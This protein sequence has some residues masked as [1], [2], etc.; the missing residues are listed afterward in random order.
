MLLRIK[1][2][3]L[4]EREVWRKGEDGVGTLL[5]FDDSGFGAYISSEVLQLVGKLGEEGCCFLDGEI[6]LV[7]GFTL[8]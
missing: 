5:V 2:A 4:L 7:E 1:I 6:F 3:E 8:C